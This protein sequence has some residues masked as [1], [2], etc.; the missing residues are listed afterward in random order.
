M[1]FRNLTKQKILKDR[2]RNNELILSLKDILT[3]IIKTST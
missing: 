2:K 3:A 1:K